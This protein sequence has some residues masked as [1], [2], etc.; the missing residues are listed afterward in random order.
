[1]G[2]YMTKRIKHFCFLFYF[3]RL[4]GVV[5]LFACLS[6]LSFQHISAPSFFFLF[7]CE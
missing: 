5:C 4:K 3:V 7:F 2:K 1:M 6:L